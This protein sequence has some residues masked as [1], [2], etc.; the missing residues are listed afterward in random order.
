M[1]VYAGQELP[2]A[3]RSIKTKLGKYLPDLFDFFK[4]SRLAPSAVD[5]D[6]KPRESFTKAPLPPRHP[7]PPR[8][9]SVGPEELRTQRKDIICRR[10]AI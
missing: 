3:R 10:T 2:W 1:E 6:A 7:A 9:D 4:L 5:L 8:A